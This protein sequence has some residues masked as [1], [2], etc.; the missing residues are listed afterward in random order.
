MLNYFFELQ[1]SGLIF[2]DYNSPETSI[3]KKLFAVILSI[4]IFG[5][6]CDKEK[7]D[8]NFQDDSSVQ[9]ING[10]WKVVSY[11]DFEK[12][13]KTVK[14]D[15]DSWNG[16]DVIMNFSNDSLW[17]YCTTNIMTGRYKL[18]GRNIHILTYGGTKIGQPEWGNMWSGIIYDLESFAVNAHQLR[19]YYDD[20]EK[21]V[22]LKKE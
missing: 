1:L 9:N 21:S 3:M 13:T 18:Y 14:T 15:V 19:L 12:G 6:G 8:E 16:M 10:K 11:E 20:S 2:V 22:T 7:I 17:G 5:I 4:L